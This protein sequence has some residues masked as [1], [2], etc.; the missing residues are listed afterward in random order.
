MQISKN[1]VL[2]VVHRTIRRKEYYGEGFIY[3]KEWELIP[4]KQ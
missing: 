1:K 2:M 4:N 3:S